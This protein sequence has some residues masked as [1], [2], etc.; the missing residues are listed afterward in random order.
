MSEALGQPLLVEPR[1]GAGTLIGTEMG[2]KA[3]ADG[4]TLVMINSSSASAISLYKKV[5]YDLVK[6]F[7]PIATIG[8]TPYVVAVHP[9]V[10]ARSL[11]QLIELARAKPGQFNYAS[12]GNGVG[13]HL[14]VE[15]FKSIAGVDLVHVPYK[16]VAPAVTALVAGEV[17]T[18]IVNLVSA[19]PHIKSGEILGLAITDETRSSLI[20]DV[21]TTA[22]AGLP[23]Y[24]FNEW[25]GLVAPFGTPP[26]VISD[27]NAPD[28]THRRHPRFQRAARQPRRQAARQVADRIRRLSSSRDRQLCPHRAGGERSDRL[29]MSAAVGAII[30]R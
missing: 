11:P 28:C 9:S 6:D 29:G 8:Y 19:L 21:P 2:A 10:P 22:E 27:L 20:P 1:P 12:A 5:P 13:S 25:Y 7:A 30:R 4:Y 23:R 15:Q 17:S 24:Q 18:M 3:P 16:G 14:A 26:K